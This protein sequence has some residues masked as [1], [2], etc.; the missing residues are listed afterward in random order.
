MYDLHTDLPFLLNRM[1]I[2]KCEKLVC[3]FYEKKLSCSY[4][5]IKRSIKS[6]TI[7]KEVHSVIQFNQE[8]WVKPYIDMNNE[9]ETNAKNDFEKDFLN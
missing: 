3:I 6:W 5:S 9:W 7:V 4:N 8:A 1:G 2:D